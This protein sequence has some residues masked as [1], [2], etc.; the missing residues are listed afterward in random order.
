MS[1]P[2]SSSEARIVPTWT[3]VTGPEEPTTF[4]PFNPFGTFM[5]DLGYGSGGYGDFSYGEGDIGSVT[6]TTVW[7]PVTSR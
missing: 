4:V 7:A 5:V 1:S 2:F 6:F 3:G